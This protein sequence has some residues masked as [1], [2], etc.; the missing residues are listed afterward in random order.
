M[1]M[2]GLLK[3]QARAERAGEMTHNGC[4]TIS[5]GYPESFITAPQYKESS[6]KKE[7]VLTNQQKSHRI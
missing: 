4:L 5:R 2:N 3:P 7:L 1:K 6:T